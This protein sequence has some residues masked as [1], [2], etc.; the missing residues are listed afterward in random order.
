MSTERD[1]VCGMEVDPAAAVRL[2]HGSHVHW[3]C[4]EGCRDRFVADPARYG[5]VHALRIDPNFTVGPH[6][7]TAPKFGAAG[8]GGL[9]YEP[10][11]PGVRD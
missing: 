7:M 5:D 3:F 1:P 4:S 2:E 6:G 11:P 9:E 8:S 10:L